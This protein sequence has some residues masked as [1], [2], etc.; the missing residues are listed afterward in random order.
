M[1]TYRLTYRMPDE[2]AARLEGTLL[3]AGS[4]DLLIDEDADVYK[5]DGTPLILYRKGIIPLGVAIKAARVLRD[6][7][8]PTK[9]RGVAAGIPQDL[10]PRKAV[11]AGKVKFR[12]VMEDGTLSNTLEATTVLSGTVGAF[13]RN[14]RFPYC[15][16]TTFTLENWD[17]VCVDVHPL[18]E[19]ASECFRTYLPDRHRTQ[20]EYV[21][22][23]HNGYRLGQTVFTTFSVNKN[24]QTAVHRD[25][26]DLKAGFGV[27]SAVRSG[28]FEGL[29]TVFPQYRVAVSMRTG[30]VCLADVHEWH[31]N[32]PLEKAQAGWERLSVVM[33]YRENM[34]RCGSPTDELEKVKH[35]QGGPLWEA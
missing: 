9:N 5:P 20:L 34:D 29:Y 10:D 3:G 2:E 18:L 26:G 23:T 31:G 32:S 4:F 19:A 15:R 12:R 6:A 17:R 27:M 7:A 24:W 30:G 22:R 35:R 21:Q 11:R 14:V 33:Y 13:D 16:L 1:K 8:K 28:T 25:A